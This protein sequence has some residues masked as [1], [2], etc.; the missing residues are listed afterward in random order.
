MDRSERSN[1]KITVMLYVLMFIYAVFTT[2]TGTQLLV[3]VREFGLDLAQGGIFAVVVNTGCTVGILLSACF[4]DR[5]D[6]RHLVLVSYFLMGILLITIRFFISYYSFLILLL[7]IGISMKFLD[8]SINAA[9][10]RLNTVN[11]G[12]Y[13]NLLHCSFGI[14]AFAGPVLRQC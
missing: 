11:S 5:F 9:I 7:L 4:I 14:G 3:L 10:S 2:M 8:A 12:F 13:M 6:S 1:L